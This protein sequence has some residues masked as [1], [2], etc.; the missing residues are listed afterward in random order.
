MKLKTL[1]ALLC[2]EEVGSLRAAA[3]QLHMSQPALSAAIQQL[4]QSL[5]APL[6][7]RSKRGVTL[8]HF[9]Q[10]FIKHARLIVAEAQRAQDEMQQLRGRWEGNITF[11]TSPAIAL[12]ALPQALSS[13]SNEYP[14]VVVRVRDGL[15]P[16]ISASLRDGSLDFAL[17]A[18][19]RYDL[20]Q[21]LVAEALYASQIVIVA[22]DNHPLI[23]AKRLSDLQ[24]CRWVFSSA[25]RGPGAIIEEAFRHYGLP[26]PRMGMVCESFLALPG[27]VA[28]SDWLTTMPRA[29]YERNAFS[30]ALRQINIEETVPSAVVYVLRRFDLP[31]T[32]AAEALVRW[33]QHHAQSLEAIKPDDIV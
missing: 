17:T 22:R 26:A 12:S 14:E 15:Y 32:P 7:V 23:N 13:F 31:L 19:H 16:G 25:P 6:L 20:E 30:A 10:A 4:E 24:D 3:Q 28:H 1:Q 27:I 33:I 29:L 8:S 5:H 9:G 18:A 11:A 2:I 21:D